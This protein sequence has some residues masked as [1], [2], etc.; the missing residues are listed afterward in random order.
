MSSTDIVHLVIGLAFLILAI[1]VIVKIANFVKE[2]KRKANQFMSMMKSVTE[3]NERTPKPLSGSEA[4]MKQRI[5]R[6]FPE[7]DVEHARQIVASVLSQYFAILNSRSGVSALRDRCTDAFVDELE[8]K[9]QNEDVKYDN[10]RLH[11]TVISDYR[12]TNSEAVVTYQAA[13]EYQLKEKTISQ[14]VYEIKYI[15]Y[16][17]E[18]DQGENVSLRCPNCGGEISSLGQKVC[19]YCGAAIE[20]SIERTWKVNKIIKTR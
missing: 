8:A 4:V 14:H 18:N 20:A 16:L 1:I 9:I 10:F 5:L 11:K 19:E 13:V 7:F 12:T 6:D 15:Y 3:E 17:S 2:T